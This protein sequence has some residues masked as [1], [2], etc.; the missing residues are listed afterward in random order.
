M[1]SLL[2]SFWTLLLFSSCDWSSDHSN[3]ET[4]EE[5]T[6]PEFNSKHRIVE[7]DAP[8]LEQDK[9]YKDGFVGN[10]FTY[11]RVFAEVFEDIEVPRL[12]P[13]GSGP[14]YVVKKDE[15]DSG[16][17]PVN[18]GRLRVKS[19][20]TPFSGKVF[21]H[22]ISGELEHHSSY[23]DGF[24]VGVAYWWRKDGS[25]SKVSRGW[26]YNYK[27]IPLDQIAENPIRVLASEMRKISTIPSDS[28]IFCGI[29]KDWDSWSA[30][31]AE[32]IIF[33]LHNGE[34]LNGEVKIFTNDGYLNT[35]KNYK[36]GLL[37]GVIA[38]FHP[39]GVQSQSI[40]Y[41]KG[42]K[43]GM[44]TWWS[45]NGFKSYSA[46][47]INGKLDGKAYSWDD[48]GYLVSE[49]EFDQGKT[50]RPSTDTSSK[51]TGVQQ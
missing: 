30:V 44:E 4:R 17:I 9:I 6:I 11:K 49:I 29:K 45:D 31:N 15:N 18:M 32:G 43:H 22:F 3:P 19:D 41:R 12:P 7:A 50:L 39:N 25:I 13:P 2:F 8:N 10:K 16:L 40:N 5:N 24:R 28:A 42:L 21:R 51:P 36:N 1:R 23:E 14:E 37:D 26:G 46:N 38:T 35:I 27:E 34:S 33:S 47:H 20:G 48:R